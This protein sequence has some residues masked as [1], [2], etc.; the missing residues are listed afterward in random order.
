MFESIKKLNNFSQISQKA[1]LDKVLAMVPVTE[2][3]SGLLKGET[4]I[5]VD[6]YA[7]GYVTIRGQ[8]SQNPTVVLQ[9]IVRGLDGTEKERP[10]YLSTLIRK[11][12]LNSG[13]QGMIGSTAAFKNASDFNYGK[14]FEAFKASAPFY[15][16]DVSVEQR[17][18][19]RD[20]Q[21]TTINSRQLELVKGE[22]PDVKA[23]A[24]GAANSSETSAKAGKKAGK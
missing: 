3:V 18:I 19:Q 6:D 24:E 4:I 9:C 8:K 5:R 22:N 11:H 7:A 12:D 17:V 10:I 21:P 2:N 14:W 13:F 20:N 16:G 23:S 1:D 15:V